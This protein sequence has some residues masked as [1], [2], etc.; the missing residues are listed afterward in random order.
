MTI[1]QASQQTRPQAEAR[2]SGILGKIGLAVGAL[3]VLDHLGDAAQELLGGGVAPHD[4]D[5]LAQS[6][7]ALDYQMANL[8]YQN[9]VLD[10][11]GT[12]QTLMD[13]DNQLGNIQAGL[14]GS[15]YTD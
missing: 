11:I 4:L 12:Q 5:S 3:F 6:D 7:H 1:S 15:M 2:G 14:N 9:H 10:S 13:V 8:A